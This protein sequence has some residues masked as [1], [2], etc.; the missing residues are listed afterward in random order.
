MSKKDAIQSH[1]E[2][3][4]QQ[5][6]QSDE[7]QVDCDGDIPVRHNTAVYTVRLAPRDTACEPHVEVYAVVVA[8][9]DAD[10][11]LYEALNSINRKL[12]HARAFWVDRKVVMASELVGPSV[13]LPTLA[14]VCDEISIAAHVEGPTLANTFGGRVACPEAID[15]EDA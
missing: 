12:S 8:D 7:L 5:Y 10:P 11:G 14:C 15:E 4:M 1:I 9:V 13:D 3:L 6:L 2:V